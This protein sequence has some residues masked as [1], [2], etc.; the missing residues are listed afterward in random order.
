MER[1]AE[2]TDSH[3]VDAMVQL[4]DQL[5]RLADKLETDIM[6]ILDSMNSV[7]PD[8]HDLLDVSRELNEM[9]GQVPGMSRMKKRI[10]QQ[11]AEEGRG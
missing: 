1:L 7:A 4:I 8:L 9:L 11:Q 2:T 10:D 6:P 5:P 3:E